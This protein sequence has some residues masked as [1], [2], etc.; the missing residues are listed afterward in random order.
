MQA[1]LKYRLEFGAQIGRVASIVNFDD[2]SFAMG[3][4]FKSPRVGKTQVNLCCIRFG[5]P[6]L[7]EYP[8]ESGVC[9][10]DQGELAVRL[11][12]FHEF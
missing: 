5:P 3:P 6:T 8:A 2:E 11:E 1:G 7:E 9:V 10:A 4:K 12:Y